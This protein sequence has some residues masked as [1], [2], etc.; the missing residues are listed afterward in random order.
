MIS[1]FK[2]D[3]VCALRSLSFYTSQTSRAPSKIIQFLTL[4]KMEEMGKL[5]YSSFIGF[6]VAVLVKRKIAKY[7]VTGDEG[8]LMN[9]AELQ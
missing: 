2:E 3:S 4:S 9:S 8:H 7:I 6:D 1:D 5:Q